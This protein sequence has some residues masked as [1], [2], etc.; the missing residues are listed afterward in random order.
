MNPG[1]TPGPWAYRP[2]EYDDW[3]IVRAGRYVIC[4]ARD[5]NV[6]YEAL[7]DYR[8]AKTDPYEANARLIASAPDLYAALDRCLN[9]IA[10]IESQWGETFECGDIARAALAKAVPPSAPS[11][12]KRGGVSSPNQQELHDGNQA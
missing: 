2:D 12:G 7:Q 4:Q 8:E 11:S 3:G 5:P 6:P 1:F 9:F 10:N